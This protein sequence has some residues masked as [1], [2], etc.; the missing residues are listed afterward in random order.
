MY[1]GSVVSEKTQALGSSVNRG[2]PPP[3]FFSDRLEAERGN[4]FFQRRLSGG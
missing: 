3:V 4:G 2:N 1:A